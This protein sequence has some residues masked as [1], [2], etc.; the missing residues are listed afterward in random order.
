MCCG[1][2]RVRPLPTPSPSRRLARVSRSFRNRVW[3]RFLWPQTLSRPA[4]GIPQRS[5]LREP[6]AV[7]SLSQPLHWRGTDQQKSGP[8]ADRERRAFGIRSQRRE[9]GRL[10]PILMTARRQTDLQLFRRLSR[11]VGPY[12]LHLPGVFLL[13]VLSTPLR[14]LT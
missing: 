9:K 2:L 5:R 8:H 1:H 11:Q 7:N 14:L 4:G 3:R 12:W 13:S 6:D 10:S